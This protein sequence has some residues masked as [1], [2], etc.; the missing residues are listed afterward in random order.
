MNADR[1]AALYEVYKVVFENI[2]QIQHQPLAQYTLTKF[3][4]LY[5]IRRALETD[6]I[7]RA[8]CQDTSDSIG[9]S[10]GSERLAHCVKNIVSELIIDLNAEVDTRDEAGTPF[11][12]KRELKNQKDVRTLA[13]TLIPQY[14]RLVSRGRVPSFGEDWENVANST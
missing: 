5:L 9:A 2:S 7:G 8:F 12:Y 11:D 6:P 13:R 4:L 10:E 14:E 1:I 3:F